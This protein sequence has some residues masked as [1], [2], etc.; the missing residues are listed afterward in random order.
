MDRISGIQFLGLVPF[1]SLFSLPVQDPVLVFAV[2]QLIIL[3]FAADFKLAWYSGHSGTV[4]FRRGAGPH[5]VF[6]REEFARVSGHFRDVRCMVR[7]L[8][9]KDESLREWSRGSMPVER[10]R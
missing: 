6:Y 4:P 1:L 8:E 2:I 10:A 9:Q 7:C 5:T 3:N